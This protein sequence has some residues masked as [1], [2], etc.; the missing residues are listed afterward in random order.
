MADRYD[1]LRNGP[2][3]DAARANKRR[4]AARQAA[5]TDQRNDDANV[6]N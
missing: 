5:T 2:T 1:N 6:V 3:C 4:G